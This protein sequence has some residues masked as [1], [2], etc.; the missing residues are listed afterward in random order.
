ME[1]EQ[2]VLQAV[3]ETGSIADSGALAQ[4]L[5]IDHNAVVGVLKSLSAA[6]M[7]LVEVRKMPGGTWLGPSLQPTKPHIRLS[8]TQSS[9]TTTAL[10][11][12]TR[13]ALS[14]ICQVQADCNCL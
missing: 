6:E 7:I 13:I 10:C 3:N 12:A 8:T 9:V 4:K 5:D 2:Q 14:C 1:L 11:W